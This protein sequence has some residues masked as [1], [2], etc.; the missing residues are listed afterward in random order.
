M[1][2]PADTELGII[3][4]SRNREGGSGHF[5]AEDAQRAPSVVVGS[6]N[7]NSPDILLG[8]AP[9][10]IVR[11]VSGGQARDGADRDLVRLWK[12][13][14]VTFRDLHRRRIVNPGAS[15]DIHEYSRGK[16]V[17]QKIKGKRG[18]SISLPGQDQNQIRRL[19]RVQFEEFSGICR[20]E[21]QAREQQQKEHRAELWTR[22]HFHERLVL[23]WSDLTLR[24]MISRH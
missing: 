14:N 20:K 9:G 10:D 22:G 1:S 8:N 5:V 3:M 2:P 13:T 24:R 18:A 12:L 21:K 7:Q 19:R 15:G 11:L 6:N 17:P 23:R 16:A 4:C